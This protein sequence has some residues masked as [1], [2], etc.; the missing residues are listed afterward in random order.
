MILSEQPTLPNPNSDINPNPDHWIV[1]STL[2][3]TVI[4]QCIAIVSSHTWLVN[5]TCKESSNAL[6]IVDF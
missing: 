2:H 3:N 4:A 6:R 1:V 5:V